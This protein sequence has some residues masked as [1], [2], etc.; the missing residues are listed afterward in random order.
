MTTPIKP[1]AILDPLVRGD[2]VCL[3]SDPDRH[4]VLD[5]FRYEISAG[6][7]TGY[8]GT[9]FAKSVE[10]VKSSIVVEW[11]D[12]ATSNHDRAELRLVRHMG[13]E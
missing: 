2:R 11:D 5:G 3:V 6:P 10:T 8:D 12:G 13:G 4:G 9:Y 1:D 7:V